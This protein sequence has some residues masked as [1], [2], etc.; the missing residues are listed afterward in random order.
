MQST[1][2]LRQSLSITL[3]YRDHINWNSLTMI[4][5]LVRLGCSVFADPNITDLFQGEHPE[6]LVGI[7]VG[8]GKSGFRHTKALIFL[9]RGKIGPRLLLL[10]LRTNKNAL[11]I[12]SKSTTLDNFEGLL[13]TLLAQFRTYS[14]FMFT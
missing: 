6:I 2:L 5:R 14:R 9:K 13:F 10:L 7:G 4:S 11:S 8:Y 3:R 1:A 12:V